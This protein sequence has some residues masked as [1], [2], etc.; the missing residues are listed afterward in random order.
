VVYS[1]K[2]LPEMLENAILV[3]IAK[4]YNKTPAQVLLRFIIQKGVSVIPKSTNSQRIVENIRV[5][6]FR[7]EKILKP[8]VI[9]LY[10]KQLFIYL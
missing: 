5:N 7:R 4:R 9:I 1:N 3:K 2:S 8:I 6:C 10:K